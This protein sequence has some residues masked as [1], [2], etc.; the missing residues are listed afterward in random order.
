[1]SAPREIWF[2]RWFWFPVHWRGWVFYLITL[3]I[4]FGLFFLIAPFMLSPPVWRAGIAFAIFM[5]VVIWLNF[6]IWRRSI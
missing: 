6:F 5:T 3:P 2:V 4:F 1:M